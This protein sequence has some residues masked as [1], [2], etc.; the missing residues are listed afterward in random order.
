MGHVLVKQTREGAVISH[1][2]LNST[3]STRTGV[4]NSLTSETQE[5]RHK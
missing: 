1:C 5:E 2:M 4:E 3:N